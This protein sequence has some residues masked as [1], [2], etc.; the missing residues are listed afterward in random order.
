VPTRPL[1][2]GNTPMAP[3]DVPDDGSPLTVPVA[4]ALMAG[5]R[6]RSG[7]LRLFGARS[8]TRGQVVDGRAAPSA[9][10]RW[11]RPARRGGV[12]TV[13]IPPT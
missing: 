4:R 9:G 2:G 11:P 7:V 13:L 5:H 8:K 3:P 1:I 10:S 12:P 6:S